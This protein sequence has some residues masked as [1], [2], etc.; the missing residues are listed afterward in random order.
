MSIFTSF[1]VGVSGL[2]SSQN[3]IN[4]TSHNL[5]NVNTPGYVRQQAVMADTHY[6]NIGTKGSYINQVGIGVDLEEV[7]RIRDILLDKS[8]RQESG[9]QEFYEAQKMAIDEVQELFGE[10]EGVAF[11]DYLEELEGAI[12]EVVKDPN[13]QV[14]RSSL[15]ESAVSFVTRANAIYDGLVEYQN[16]LNKE[17]ENMVAEINSLGEKIHTLNQKISAI[18]SAG[19]E[20]ANDL[21]DERDVAL[22]RL[23]ELAKIS[24]EEDLDGIVE[25]KVEGVVFVNRVDVNYMECKKMDADKGSVLVTPVWPF[26]ADKEVYN[27]NQPS[28]TK[29]NTDIGALKGLL[30]ARGDSTANYTDIPNAS[31]SEKYPNGKEDDQ[32]KKDLETYRVDIEQSTIKTVMAEIDQLV[33][34]IVTEMNDIFSPNMSAADM[35]KKLNY[36]AANGEGDVNGLLAAV[37]AAY[38]DGYEYPEGSGFRYE[39]TADTKFFNAEEAG[40]GYGDNREVQG[41]ELFSRNYTDRYVEIE[42]NGEKLYIFNEHNEFGNESLYTLGNLSVNEAVLQDYT[43]IP[44]S[45]KDGGEDRARAEMLGQVWDNA[46]LKLTP[47]YNTQKSYMEYYN[48]FTGQIANA[49]RLYDN[50]IEYQEELA[51]GIDDERQRVMGVSSDEELTNLIKYQAA[52]N[53]SSRYINVI[54]E[55]L[56][57]LITRL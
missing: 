31:D 41:T 17:I 19:I 1:S 54:N 37:E 12:Q 52:Y 4:T 39:I 20:N 28:T 30:L 3:A 51:T 5:A 24:Y 48:E 55:M 14:T 33:N 43:L 57:H 7:R 25:V 56:E 36:T 35:A 6:L 9:R 2:K 50:M 29:K 18:E 32:Y 46:E 10:L 53:A 38:P 22:D 42:L 13:S 27:L 16:T 26:L 47:D 34:A 40:Y 15:I 21:R 23:A 8:F 45:L 44:L 49:G 11:Q